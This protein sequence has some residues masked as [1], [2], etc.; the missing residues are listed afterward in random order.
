MRIAGVTCFEEKWKKIFR[1]ALPLE[2]ESR[3]VVIPLSALI[4]RRYTK[5]TEVSHLDAAQLLFSQQF[6]ALCLGVA[7]H[8]NFCSETFIAPPPPQEALALSRGLIAIT[9]NKVF[10]HLIHT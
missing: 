5:V 2:N 3:V 10:F 4:L 7:V 1:Q 6:V 9:D 8:G